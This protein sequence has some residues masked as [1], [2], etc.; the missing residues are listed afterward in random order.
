MTD[1]KP[2]RRRYQFSLRTLPVFVLLVAIGMSWFAVKMNE[3]RKQREAVEAIVAAGGW[4]DYDH[5]LG[6]DGAD[7]CALGRRGT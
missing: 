6:E 1:P 7:L 4:V 2:Q 3:A 5:Q